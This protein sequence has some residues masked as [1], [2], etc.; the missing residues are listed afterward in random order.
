MSLR[1]N[2]A[3]ISAVQGR[4]LFFDA[5]VLLYLFGSVATP[6]NQ[7][8]ITAYSAIF[9]QCL[10][11]NATLCLDVFVLSEFINRVLR[12]EYE[13][14]LKINNLNGVK[15]KYKVFRSKAEGIQAA[16]DVESVVKGRI[17]GRFSVVGKLFDAAD[18]H[19]ISFANSDFNDELI[20]QTCLEHQ[21]VLVINDADFSG[22]NIDILTANTKLK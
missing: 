20:I 4:P 9:S 18:L 15:C 7:W 6:S 12:S 16:Q 2:P 1:L 11:M 3:S 17:L 13:N 14:Y 21:C 5:N 10:K 8:A 19:S 22:A